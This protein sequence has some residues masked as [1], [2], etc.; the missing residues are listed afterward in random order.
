LNF[1][2]EIEIEFEFELE[3]GFK[4]QNYYFLCCIAIF[5]KVF[6]LLGWISCVDLCKFYS[7]SSIQFSFI[8]SNKYI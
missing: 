7:I 4:L 1:E 8:L 6:L 3:F 5:F 2:F